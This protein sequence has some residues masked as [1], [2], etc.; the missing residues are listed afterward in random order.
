MKHTMMHTQRQYG[1]MG[2]TTTVGSWCFRPVFWQY[3][4]SLCELPQSAH[5]GAFGIVFHVLLVL[6]A[7]PH[8]FDGLCNPHGRTTAQ[9][10]HAMTYTIKRQYAMNTHRDTSTSN[11]TYDSMKYEK[12]RSI[13]SERGV[14]VCLCCIA[15]TPHCTPVVHYLI[16][17]PQLVE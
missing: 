10:I 1:W 14:C 8:W 15:F 6:C 12:K 3:K 16:S 11:A 17:W 4:P 7:S 13:Y 5:C 2:V 9:S